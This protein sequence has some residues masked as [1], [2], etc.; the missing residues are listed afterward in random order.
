MA[1]YYELKTLTNQPH[2][3]LGA[4]IARHLGARQDLGSAVIVTS[5][6]IKLITSFRKPCLNLAGRLQNHRAA[7]LNPKKTFRFTH[8][9]RLSQ[10]RNFFEKTPLQVPD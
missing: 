6:P 3:T 10:R 1:H 8:T 5:E 7:T 4:E 9:I 2:A